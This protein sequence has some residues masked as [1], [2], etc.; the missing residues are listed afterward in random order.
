[1]TVVYQRSWTIGAGTPARGGR[2]P[3][4]T[5]ALV[6]QFVTQLAILGEA[7][8]QLGGAV[9]KILPI[10]LPGVE[11]FAIGGDQVFKIG[12]LGEFRD[13]GCGQGPGFHFVVVTMPQLFFIIREAAESFFADNVFNPNEASI[14]CIAV[15]DDALVQI[16]AKVNAKMRGLDL[17]AD[18]ISIKMKPVEVCAHGIK[19]ILWL[20]QTR[21]HIQQTLFERADFTNFYG[22]YDFAADHDACCRGD[23]SS[24]TG[25]DTF[26]IMSHS[27]TLVRA[28]TMRKSIIGS[29]R[30]SLGV[31][32]C[33]IVSLTGRDNLALG[34]GLFDVFGYL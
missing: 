27:P 33:S 15:K 29:A 22:S 28:G 18:V 4:S 6:N 1:G 23:P 19:R 10:V 17:P 11:G 8:H 20:H 2:Q 25:A 32:V 24:D 13:A 9:G 26:E 5:I 12:V 30:P 21:P 34:P 7:H 31:V 3:N 16:V 14:G